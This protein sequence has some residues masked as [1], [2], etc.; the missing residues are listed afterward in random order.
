MVCVN[1][2]GKVAKTRLLSSKGDEVDRSKQNSSE[3]KENDKY[4]I[5]FISANMKI[6]IEELG[7]I[8]I[9]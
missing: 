5:I 6:I 8:R 1:E 4:L 9:V 7:E 2:P 3:S